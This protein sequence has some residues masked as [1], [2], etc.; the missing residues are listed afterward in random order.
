MLLSCAVRRVFLPVLL[1]AAAVLPARA[2]AQTNP[3]EPYYAVT[4]RADVPLKSGDMDGYYP[5][6]V[7]PA[8]QV[9]WVDAEGAGWARVAYPAG[10]SVFVRADEVREEPGARAVVLTRVSA[11]KSRN[12]TA[13]FAQS[14]QRAIPSHS[15]AAIG[16]RLV[17]IEPIKG[18]DGSTIGYEVQPP[19]AVRGYVKAEALRAATDAEVQAYLATAPKPADEPVV[20]E[21]VVDEP[22]A[23]EPAAEPAKEPVDDQPDPA[24]DGGVLEPMTPTGER[25]V[26]T[27]RE[28]E[29]GQPQ[30]PGGENPV[31]ID[32][33]P[34]DPTPESR[35]VGT[36]THL[37]ELFAQV[38]RQNSDTA[39]LDELAAEFRRAISAQGDDVVGARIRAALSQR[40]QLVETRIAAR[41]LRRSLR[42]KRD[43]IDATYASV[44]GR[45]RELEATRGYQFVGRLVRSS[46]YDGVRLPLMYR[47]VSVNESVPRTIGYIVPDESMDITGKLGEI[48]GVLGTSQLDTALNLRLV[49][50][51]RVDVLAA[52]GLGLPTPAEP[53]V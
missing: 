22:P 21:P 48:V 47:I 49:T 39:E 46:V 38:Q 30:A 36:L 33:T 26:R 19:S 24:A 27:Q 9:L 16:T 15:E 5:V 18:P 4:T 45:V 6:T 1:C 31:V 3:V 2:P 17:V 14:W 42:A 10:L 53:G 29:Q 44:A 11:L 12:S 41:D 40:L 7:L 37:A 52:E 50:P 20:E 34:A 35:L 28:P 32:Q 25:P 8:G 13:G 43:A 23:K 51:T